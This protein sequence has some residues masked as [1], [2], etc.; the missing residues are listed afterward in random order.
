[1]TAFIQLLKLIDEIPD[2][3]FLLGADSKGSLCFIKAV[4]QLV[5]S[6]LSRCQRAFQTSGNIL[7]PV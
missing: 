1:M 5:D 6:I 7:H 4:L 2:L 3:F